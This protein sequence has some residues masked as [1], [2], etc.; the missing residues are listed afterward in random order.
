MV[1]RRCDEY[2]LL[3]CEDCHKRF[4]LLAEEYDIKKTYLTCPYHGRHKR[5]TVSGKYEDIDGCMKAGE[6]DTDKT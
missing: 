6:I 3:K 1:K 4:T 5:I 2:I